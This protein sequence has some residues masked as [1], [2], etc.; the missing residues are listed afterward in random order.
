MARFALLG[1]ALGHFTY[2]KLAGNGGAVS[3]GLLT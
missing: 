1:E 2:V 3:G